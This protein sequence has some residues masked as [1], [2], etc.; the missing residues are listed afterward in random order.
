MWLISDKAEK[1][2]SLRAEIGDL[3]NLFLLQQRKIYLIS[4]KALI[5]VRHRRTYCGF[6]HLFCHSLLLYSTT[7]SCLASFGV[8]FWRG[9]FAYS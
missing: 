5:T 9:F 2:W 4:Q 6:L 3:G 1:R 8:L 7:V